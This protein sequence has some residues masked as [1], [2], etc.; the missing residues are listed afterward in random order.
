M[1]GRM[2]NDRVT[3][4]NLEI[5]G[6]EG[7]TLLV[8][9][10]V[11]GIR[12]AVVVVKKVGKNKKFKP[13]WSEKPEIIEQP[14]PSV[15]ETQEA[16]PVVDATEKVQNAAETVATP[17]EKVE[18]AQETVVTAE[19]NVKVEGE[20]AE[21]PVASEKSV[22]DSSEESASIDNTGEVKEENAS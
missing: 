11:P 9:G 18:T 8:K 1:S 17:E 21:E 10:L 20:T 7:D 13:L 16:Q 2:G 6:I 3:V 5:L 22:E 4:K 14:T 19:E 12:G 15:S